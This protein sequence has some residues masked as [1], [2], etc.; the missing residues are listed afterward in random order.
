MLYEVLPTRLS[1]VH[2]RGRKEI[3]IFRPS[4]FYFLI[5]I[6]YSYSYSYSYFK[7]PPP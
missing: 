5:P 6:S 1:V 7:F 2:V 4:F 3:L